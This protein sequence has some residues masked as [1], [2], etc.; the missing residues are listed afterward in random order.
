MRKP[1]TTLAIVAVAAVLGGVTVAATAGGLTPTHP[2]AATSLVKGSGPAT[3]DLT[4]PA[5]LHSTLAEVG[6]V[7]QIIL[8]DAKGLPLYT[9]QPDTATQSMVAGQLAALWPPLASNAPT[10][11]GLTGTWN[12]PAFLDTELGCLYPSSYSWGVK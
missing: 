2:A 7:K 8:V 3:L 12:V 4:A 1:R 9:Y 5:T 6:G 11:N 10:S